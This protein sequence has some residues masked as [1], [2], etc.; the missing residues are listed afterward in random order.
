MSIDKKM[1]MEIFT[2][3]AMSSNEIGMA[4]YI[5]KKLQEL[6]IDYEKDAHGNI[7]KLDGAKPF[8]NSHMDTVQDIEDCY[9]VNHISIKEDSILDGLGVI[10][11]DD[12]CGIYIILRILEKGYDINFSFSVEEETG[13]HGARKLVAAQKD[14]LKECL[15]GI[16]L[17]RKGNSD[18]ICSY[19]GYGTDEFEEA[20][21]KVGEEFEYKPTP[22]VL[23]DADE[24]NKTMSCANL[25][26]GYYRA[27]TKG[28]FVILRDLIKAEKYVE[29]ILQNIT[30]KFEI[31]EQAYKYTRY[32]P[33][34][35]AYGSTYYDDYYYNETFNFSKKD[36]ELY[37]EDDWDLEDYYFDF[38]NKE[39]NHCSICGSKSDVHYIR[40]LS[41]HYCGEC[42][43]YI[44]SE[45]YAVSVGSSELGL[46]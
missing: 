24:F 8:L 25:S 36:R 13:L 34:R 19:N 1:L 28:E 11:G 12:K 15:Y 4:K 18:I 39:R 33:G 23:S 9:L 2:I 46:I 6:G 3:P 32:Y 5:E 40:T 38:G 20:L 21:S 27:H 45:I 35:S 17:D 31:P 26:V 7:F 43:S 14:R 22:G 16:T 29:S 44:E 42:L 41:N 30:E 10:G 37:G